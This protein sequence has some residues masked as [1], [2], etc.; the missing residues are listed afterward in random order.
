MFGKLFRLIV[1]LVIG[2]LVYNFFLGD[3]E[4]KES[5]RRIFGEAKELGIAVKEL[6]KSEKEK[7]DEGKYDET[8]DKIGGLFR[9]VK[10]RAENIDDEYLDQ[11]TALDEKRK[12]LEK[13]LAD[14]SEERPDEYGSEDNSRKIQRERKRIQ[15][16]LNELME[17]TEYVMKKIEEDY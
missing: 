13:R 10:N 16:E 1:I 5:A 4:E 9:K 8:L 11:I 6:I 12:D 7:F 14:L 2:I 3:E 15:R 17:E